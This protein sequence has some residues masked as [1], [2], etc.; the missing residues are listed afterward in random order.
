MLVP[1][2]PAGPVAPVGPLTLPTSCTDVFEY[3]NVKLSPTN[4]ELVIPTPLVPAAP[5]AP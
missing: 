2:A 4:A 5:V 3:V 1:S